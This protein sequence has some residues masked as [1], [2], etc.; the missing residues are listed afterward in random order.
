MADLLN[1]VEQGPASGTPLVLIHPLGADRH[2]FDE[3]V[4][5]FGEGV[6]S[7]QL[8]LRGSGASVDLVEPLTLN[9]TV[10]DIEAVRRHLG[11]PRIVVAGC[12]IG[13]MA[14][15]LYAASHADRTAGLVMSNP[16]IRITPAA[17]ENL[18]MRAAQVRAKGMASLLPAAIENAFVGY[19]ETEGRRRYEAAFVAQKAENYALA[20]LG[21][22]GADLAGELVRIVCPTLL[23]VGARDALMAPSN[24]AEIAGLV[25]HALTTEFEDG[26]HFI[27]Y[28]QPLRF[29]ARVAGFLDQY[30]LR[31]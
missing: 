7:I 5:E 4:P 14:A 29:G 26:A 11:L 31:A 9:Q 22:V 21:A 24:A 3:A 8:D 25:P 12:A 6:R 2:F 28:Q 27:P 19:T 13:G 18:T 16:A 20:C 1:F 30:G 10:A 23:I 15:A 17:G